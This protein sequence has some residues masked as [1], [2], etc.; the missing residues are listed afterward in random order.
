MSCT[1]SSVPFRDIMNVMQKQLVFA[2]ALLLVFT[3]RTHNRQ[4]LSS[5]VD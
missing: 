3:T 1:C 4:I 2:M 5:V